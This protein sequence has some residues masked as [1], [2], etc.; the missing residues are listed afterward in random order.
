MHA[1][2]SYRKNMDRTLIL[3]QNLNLYFVS[4]N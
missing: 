2:S 4:K 3:S 1:S